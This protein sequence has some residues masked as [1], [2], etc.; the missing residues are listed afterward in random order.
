[1]LMLVRFFLSVLL[2]LAI[3]LQGFAATAMLG[4]ATSTSTQNSSD[5]HAKALHQHDAGATASH[6][7]SSTSVHHSHAEKSKGGHSD[8]GKCSVCAACCI[9]TLIVNSHNKLHIPA[10]ESAAIPF[11]LPF[12]D[13]HTP[14]GLDPPPRTF[15][16]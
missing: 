8:H 6:S 12:F 16:A 11:A 1:M 9:G 15:L 3:P 14:E 7:P 2:V 5:V 4:C 10:I 13:S